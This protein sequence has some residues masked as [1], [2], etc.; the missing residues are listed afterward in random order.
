[1]SK[2]QKKIKSKVDKD[3]DR[4]YKSALLNG[5]IQNRNDKDKTLVTLSSAGIGLIITLLTQIELNNIFE[6]LFYI[7]ALISFLAS[8]FTALLIFDAN[9]KYLLESYRDKNPKSIS[10]LDKICQGA[11]FLGVVMLTLITFSILFSKIEIKKN[12]N[13]DKDNI[14]HQIDESVQEI[15]KFK[16]KPKKK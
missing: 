12:M 11:F 4:M 9:S 5:W 13:K 14:S 6:C 1:M 7:L 15:E 3:D 8:I 16:P 10:Y 2:A